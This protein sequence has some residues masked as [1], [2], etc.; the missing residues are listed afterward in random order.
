[1]KA[2]NFKSYIFASAF[3]LLILSAAHAACTN[4][5]LVGAY[6]FQ[7]QGQFPGGGYYEFRTVGVITFDGHGHGSR[8]GTIW[9]GGNPT[10]VAPGDVNS[11]SY[12][13]NSDCTFNYTYLT[14]GE[15]FT[16]VIVNGG[17]KMF[18]LEIN[19]NGDPMRSGQA[20]RVRSN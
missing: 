1:M 7:E 2:L 19:A 4:A 11:I 14:N 6:G 5:N 17:Q 13:V 10:F 8:T 18:W 20:E 3:L 12:T 15:P 16:G 9:Y